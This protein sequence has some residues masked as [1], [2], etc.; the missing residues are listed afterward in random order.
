MHRLSTLLVVLLSTGATTG[1]AAEEAEWSREAA[2]AEIEE[3]VSSPTQ[4]G[5]SREK[6][7]KIAAWLKRIETTKLDLGESSFVRAIAQFYINQARAAQATLLG[8]LETHSEFPRGPHDRYLGR[9]LL[10]MTSTAVSRREF[11]KLELLLPHA[12]AFQRD[13]KLFYQRVG[14][15]LRQAASP[16]SFKILN[17]L[18]RRLLDEK[19]IDDVE[20]QKTIS[21]I[22]GKSFSLGGGLTA[23]GTFRGPK[24]LR[25]FR[26]KDL[27]GKVIDLADY[28]GK[29]VLVDF[30]ATW[31]GPCIREVPNVVKTYEDLRDQ[32]FEVIGISLDRRGEEERLR[33]TAERLEMTWPQIYDGGGWRSKLAVQNGIR[34]IP[35]TYL[36]DRAG[37]VRYTS[38]R[39]PA[40]AEKVKELLAEAPP[41]DTQEKAA[42]ESATDEAKPQASA[43]GTSS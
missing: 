30:W 42:S 21:L 35:A 18:L 11:D 34:S 39:G 28:R 8:Y 32:G 14:A 16:S 29:V 22:Y 41:E 17:D 31:C 10:G 40:L 37:R 9:I 24:P 6:R 12:L 36:V 26:E 5:S 15:S 4:P 38:L 7:D 19:E 13:R 1:F 3:L 20:I 25:P 27:D 33:S 23:R 2:L 43:G